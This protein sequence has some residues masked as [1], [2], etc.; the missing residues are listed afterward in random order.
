MKCME[1]GELIHA[2]QSHDLD[3]IISLDLDPEA[4]DICDFDYIYSDKF[5]VVMRADHPL[6]SSAQGVTRDDLAGMAILLPRQRDYPGMCEFV[7]GFIPSSPGSLQHSHYSDID[8]LY[9][10]LA[11]NDLIAFSS[12]HN[13]KVAPEG[14][15]FL[16]VLDIDTSYTISTRWLKP[17]DRCIVDA[18]S[19]VIGQCRIV[20]QKWNDGWQQNDT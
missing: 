11:G 3:V 12:G 19:G 1:Y 20:M 13:I 5:Y 9:M 10:E 4:E 14:M 2:H 7:E 16:P 18:I 15:V 17:L 6:A 8:T